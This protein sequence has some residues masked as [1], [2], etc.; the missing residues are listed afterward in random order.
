MF[1]LCKHKKF[2]Q[3]S[4]LFR[5]FF[6]PHLILNWLAGLHTIR[7]I[8]QQT[9]IGDLLNLAHPA[10]RPFRPGSP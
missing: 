3:Q 1:S 7:Q 5:L 9:Q 8:L 6:V 10:H 2:S 4:W